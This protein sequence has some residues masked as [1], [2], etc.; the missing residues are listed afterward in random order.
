MGAAGY[1]RGTTPFLD[2]VTSRGAFFENAVGAAPWTK[3]A[4][5]SLVTGTTPGV[6]RMNDYYKAEDIVAGRVLRKRLLPRS[7]PVLG[8]LAGRVGYRT[9]A[10]V[11]N[12]HAGSFFGITR[13]FADERGE[14]TITAT[15]AI[16]EL[17]QWVDD[18]ARSPF[19]AFFVLADPHAPYNP[20]Y[21]SYRRFT[22]APQ[23]VAPEGY[24]AHWQGVYERV[25]ARL[26]TDRRW[27][28]E[29][30]RDWEDLYDAELAD[31]DRALSG[32]PS[33]LARSV[34]GR[35]NLLV[36][37]ADHGERF[38]E[39]GRVDHGHFPDEATIKIPMIVL[40]S[41][42]PGGRRVREVVR[43][44]DPL[45]T[46][47]EAMGFEVPAVVQGRSLRPLLDGEAEEIPR[48]AFAVGP[49]YF[50]ALRRGRFKYRYFP[51]LKRW[52]LFDLESDPMETRDLSADL[53]EEGRSMSELLR[54]HLSEERR[55][56]TALGSEETEA[57]PEKVVESLR[58]LGYLR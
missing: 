31:L 46:L 25:M 8:E 6:H 27:S 10:R 17:A 19:L 41:G 45:P 58:A 23:P 51:E 43:S 55:L 15:S 39:S 36:I 24:P 33:A 16:E 34:N 22:R 56:R 44:I 35:R 28:E 3:P 26:L 42:P 30:R 20:S 38:F 52:R 37:T 29:D 54:A 57:L 1:P 14:P 9:F 2:S 5:A 21:E 48:V 40:D 32:L 53:P 47:A 50:P 4:V 12:V 7:L 13:G 49:G 18:D 11:N